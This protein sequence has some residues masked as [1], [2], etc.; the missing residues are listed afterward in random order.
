M[1]NG[2]NFGFVG[3]LINNSEM[4]RNKTPVRQG[5]IYTSKIRVLK[6][7]KDS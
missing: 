1:R 7:M 4:K 2:G 3:G 5:K 6:N